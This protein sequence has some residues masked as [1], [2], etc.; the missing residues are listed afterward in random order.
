MGTVQMSGSL[1]KY[2]PPTKGRVTVGG[3][4]Y[5][6]VKIGTQ[7]WTVDNIAYLFD[8]C[9]SGYVATDDAPYQTGLQGQPEWMGFFYNHEAAYYLNQNRET[10]LPTGW[11]VPNDTDWNRFIGYVQN[12]GTQLDA[13][14]SSG[15]TNEPQGTDLYGFNGY[16]CGNFVNSINNYGLQCKIWSSSKRY[17]SGSRV[18]QY[19]PNFIMDNYLTFMV[20]SQMNN[21]FMKIRLV[22]DA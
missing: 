11:K 6:T 5:S 18:A 7:W 15:W 16:P 14:S 12:N 22:K 8:G 13:C 9:N 19:Q 1:L 10:L 4:V 21:V 20:G 3:K 17:D 2:T